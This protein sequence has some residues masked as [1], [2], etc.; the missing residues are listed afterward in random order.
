[1]DYLLRS[2]FSGIALALSEFDESLEMQSSATLLEM[3]IWF[4]GASVAAALIALIILRYYPISEKV[5]MQTRK[6]LEKTRG[7]V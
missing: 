1:M 3:R 4:V 6:A 7:K 5:A 2:F